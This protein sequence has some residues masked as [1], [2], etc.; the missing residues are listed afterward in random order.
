[1]FSD[2]QIDY[3]LGHLTGEQRT[4]LGHVY[5]DISRGVQTLCADGFNILNS[6][7]DLERAEVTSRTAALRAK[8]AKDDDEAP[9]K[10]QTL[11][12]FELAYERLLRSGGNRLKFFS[13]DGLIVAP[14]LFGDR[15]AEEAIAAKLWATQEA[16]WRCEFGLVDLYLTQ[17]DQ[18]VVTLRGPAKPF[19]KAKINDLRVETLFTTS[20]RVYQDTALTHAVGAIA[21]WQHLHKPV[22]LAHAFLRKAVVERQRFMRSYDV[23]YLALNLAALQTALDDDLVALLR[24]DR[25]LDAK[26]ALFSLYCDA[27]KS[28]AMVGEFN[29]AAE[30]YRAA[31]WVCEELEEIRP[32]R[33]IDLI[34]AEAIILEGRLTERPYPRDHLVLDDTI[35]RMTAAIQRV[36]QMYDQDRVLKEVMIKDL[37]PLLILT[38]RSDRKEEAQELLNRSLADANA[39]GL[40]HQI[41]GIQ[42]IASKYDLPLPA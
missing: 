12:A 37:I 38:G 1:V 2:F 20:Q 21:S 35:E 6:D 23:K 18:A 42:M 3:V 11:L 29:S 7:H 36:G 16:R 41:R 25:N 5:S 17:L 26:N 32:R 39:Y 9:A 13:A 28:Y 4:V 31:A 22:E 24:R 40:Y 27:A 15:H 34:R 8:C 14:H 30:L 33:E 10:L 19:W